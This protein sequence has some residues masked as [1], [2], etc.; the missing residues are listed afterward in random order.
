VNH[1][2]PQHV[3]VPL[4]AHPDRDQNRHVHDPV[5]DP[6]LLVT[7]VHEHVGELAFEGSLPPRLQLPI[8][9][10]YVPA[11][12]LV[13]E[14]VSPKSSSQIRETFRVETPCT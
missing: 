6:R 10:A 13:R 1:L 8:Q 3:P 9:L 11:D 7:S 5:I 4:R 12:R 14:S 2:D